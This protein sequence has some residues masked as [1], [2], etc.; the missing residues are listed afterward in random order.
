MTVRVIAIESCSASHLLP[1]SRKR[2]LKGIELLHEGPQ[3]QLRVGLQFILKWNEINHT[4]K[5]SIAT[6]WLDALTRAAALGV[7]SQKAF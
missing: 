5:G 1:V 3:L 6:L 7:T 2:N 4:S